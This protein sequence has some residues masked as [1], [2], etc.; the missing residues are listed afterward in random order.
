VQFVPYPTIFILFKSFTSPPASGKIPRLVFLEEKR[1][2]YEENEHPP[3]A[4]PLHTASS[5]PSTFWSQSSLSTLDFINPLGIIKISLHRLLYL[6]A[7]I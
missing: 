3:P 4:P 6:V 5:H 1:L 2:D 7:R